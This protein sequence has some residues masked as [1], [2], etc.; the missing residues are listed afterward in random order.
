MAKRI[1]LKPLPKREPLALVAPELE[2]PPSAGRKPSTT[3]PL[4]P[5]LFRVT[6]RQKRALTE[7]AIRRAQERGLAKLDSSEVLREVLEAWLASKRAR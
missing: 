7:E 3:E 4:V 1:P 6:A 5:A 2:A